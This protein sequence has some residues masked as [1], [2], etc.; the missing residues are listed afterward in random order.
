M[1]GELKEDITDKSR[2]LSVSYGAGNAVA[3]GGCTRAPSKRV[4]NELRN[5][6]CAIPI[7][8]FRTTFTNHEHACSLKLVAKK[9]VR[10]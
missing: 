5:Q 6:V 4:Y 8:V 1:F 9:S 10:Q 7:N 2:C 3:L